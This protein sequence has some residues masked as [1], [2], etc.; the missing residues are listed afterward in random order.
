GFEHLALVE[1]D[2]W[3]CE[4]LRARRPWRERVREISVKEWRA[5]EL[6]GQVDLFAGGVPCPPF[7]RAGQRLG[8]GDDR[9]LFPAAIELIA[10]CRPRAVMLENVRG[11]LSSE[12][13]QYRRRVI[14]GPLRELGLVPRWKLLHASHYGVPQL[15]PRVVLVALSDEAD[16]TFDWPQERPRGAPTV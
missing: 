8:A 7:S 14:E 9:D 1:N 13:D 12:F 15:R 2:H 4:T 3:C 16:A 5:T 11:L 10:E 6:R